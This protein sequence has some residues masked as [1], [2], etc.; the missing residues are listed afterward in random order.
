MKMKN[1]TTDLHPIDAAGRY[2]LCRPRGGLNDALNQI[3][4][5]W[6][7]A[8]NYHRELIIDTRLSGLLGN[9]FDYFAVKESNISVREILNPREIMELNQSTTLPTCCKGRLEGINSFFLNAN[10][11]FVDSD[12]QESITFDFSVDHSESILI[13][14]Q[15]GGGTLSFDCLN[16][17]HL[18]DGILPIVLSR[19]EL[20]PRSY[21]GV[22]IRNTDYQSDYEYYFPK[23]IKKFRGKSVLVCS[24]DAA[25][26]QYAKLSFPSSN[27]IQSSLSAIQDGK[28]LHEFTTYLTEEDCRVATINSLIDLLALGGAKTMYFMVGEHGHAS[29]YSVLAAYLCKNKAVINSL[30]KESLHSELDLMGSKAIL[31]IPTSQLLIKLTPKIIRP[32]FSRFIKKFSIK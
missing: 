14:E 23:L 5:C 31:L 12:T 11:N 27:I 30:L 1:L 15:S 29:G 4:K 25:V 21:D 24:D 6:R 32:V 22:H 8:E 2:L 13:H 10:K 17:L 18:S 20:L 16:R 26:I 3:E 9:F 28:P 19:L 7:Y